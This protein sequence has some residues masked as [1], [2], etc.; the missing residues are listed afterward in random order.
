[1]EIITKLN[2]FKTNK[3]IIYLTLMIIGGL[4][5]RFYYFPIDVPIATDGYFS[6]VYANKI[7]FE[8]SLPIGYTTTNTGWS[9]LLALFFQGSDLSQPLQ[10][11]HIQRTLS[12]IFSTII[13]IPAFFIF[14][15][16][17]NEK[18][19]LFGSFLL[20]MEPRLLLISIEGLNYSLY[21][22]LFV[23][24]IALFLKK[25][26]YSFS[27]AF[28]LIA[29]SSI[30]RFEGLLLIIPGIIIYVLR[31]NEKRSFKKLAC[32]LIFVVIIL[33]P[34][35]T[36]RMD[37]TENIC[38]NYIIDEVCGGDGI[39]QNIIDGVNFFYDRG[40]MQTPVTN[41]ED[42]IFEN[43]ESV[44]KKSGKYLF[45]SIGIKIIENL[46]KFS[47]W[48]T[49]PYFIFFISLSILLLIKN[50]INLK[51]NWNQ[52]TILI[53]I[54]IMILPAIYAY[55]R[56]I[57]EARYVLVI[58]PALCIISIYFS[59]FVSKKILDNKKIF[60]VLI[61]LVLILS[62]VF[63]ELKKRDKN[64]D[65]ESYLVSEKIIELTD[66]TNRFYNGGYIKAA[67]L[68]SEW[69][70]LPKAGDNGKLILDYTSVSTEEYSNFKNFMNYSEKLGL[71]YI[72]IDSSNKFY[73]ELKENEYKYGY[74]E[75]E[76]N[77][78]E[79][80]FD[81]EFIIYKINYEKKGT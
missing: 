63:V 32:M 6:F 12:I 71:N 65:Y 74:L 76:F 54:G 29:F 50:K 77:S 20:I 66:K 17:V 15:K 26:N 8:E 13:C 56:E 48:I 28:M 30:V 61:I 40:V 38:H 23:T 79:L 22:F 34:V 80:G 44:D 3:S 1:M 31:S 55:A 35:S 16:F 45:N 39:T 25:T 60:V 19:S 14:K 57:D 64:H 7:I 21:Y 52:K 68:I 41:P 78:K 69:P 72:I 49:I 46:L 9:Y 24:I 18:W 11:M 67:I 81:N 42:K 10:L 53:T 5:I 73:E 33:A 4:I 47:A 36:I 70:N 59:K 51:L 75:K 2:K 27:I 43:L 37:A 62:L 58:L